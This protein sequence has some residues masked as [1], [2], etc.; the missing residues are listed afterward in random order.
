M[1]APYTSKMS[2]VEIDYNFWI[3][4]D[5]ASYVIL[6]IQNYIWIPHWI[7]RFNSI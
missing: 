5:E 2:R 6:K 4:T 3:E 7:E 1:S